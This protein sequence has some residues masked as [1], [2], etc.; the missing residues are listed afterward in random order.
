M[1]PYVAPPGGGVS[2]RLTALEH[3]T[4]LRL[5][6]DLPVPTSG[7][8]ASG[9]GAGDS[10]GA[11]AGAPRASELSLVKLRRE[12]KQRGVDSTGVKGVLVD[13]LQPHLDMEQ[14]MFD[15]AAAAPTPM[16]LDAEPQDP[17]QHPEPLLLCEGERVVITGLLGAPELN[18]VAGRVS[19]RAWQILLPAIIN[20]RG[21]PSYLEEEVVEEEQEEDGGTWHPMT[22]RAIYASH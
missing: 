17:E 19:G 22:W 5:K 1:I 13:R 20:T 12:L 3:L 6:F 15:L 8:Q 9:A 11:A 14:G 21:K 7:G 16:N 4:A 10:A 18:G 2:T